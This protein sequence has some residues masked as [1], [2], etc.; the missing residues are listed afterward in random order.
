MAPAP[1]VPP[2]CSLR[3]PEAKTNFPLGHGSAI[4]SST[5]AAAVAGFPFLHHPHNLA[6][7]PDLPP[8][9]R[10]TSS[11]LRSTVESFNRRRLWAPPLSL[12]S[13]SRL[14][15]PA[16]PPPPHH[17]STTGAKAALAELVGREE[18]GV[19]H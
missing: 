10:P 14:R 18:G 13:S 11:S 5:V 8:P 17:R 1:T 6:S 7:P 3:G 15:H 19:V 9:Q 12:R 4:P 2:P 16:N